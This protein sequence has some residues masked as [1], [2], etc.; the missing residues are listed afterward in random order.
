M[1]APRWIEAE[2]TSERYELSREIL[3]SISGEE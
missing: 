1:G 3:F 2:R